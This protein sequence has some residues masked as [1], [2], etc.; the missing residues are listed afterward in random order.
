M[1]ARETSFGLEADQGQGVGEHLLFPR[2]DIAGIKPIDF[3][4]IMG[5]HGQCLLLFAILFYLLT[6][7]LL[8]SRKI[9]LP[10]IRTILEFFA[11]CNP[12]DSP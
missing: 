6:I 11:N 5:T 8:Q 9:H 2:A 1:N 12:V 7:E 3:A 4:P 10:W